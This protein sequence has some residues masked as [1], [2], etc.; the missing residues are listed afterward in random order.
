[1][2][3]RIGLSDAD[4][5]GWPGV[6][7]STLAETCTPIA[8]QIARARV[9]SVGFIPA[10][11]ALAHGEA[12]A[13]LIVAI[14]EALLGFL[15]EEIGIIDSWPT[16]PWG[17]AAVDHRS[18]Y[19]QRWLAPRIVELAPLPCGDPQ[20]A[21]VALQATLAS[22]PERTAVILVNLAGYVEPGVIPSAL[23]FVDGAI[24]VVAS[25]RTLCGG[26]ARM[27]RFVPGRKN[28]GAVLVA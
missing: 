13:P 7:A 26:L 24:L 16:W 2:A 22:R 21:A 14:G 4:R 20:A 23:D 10:A 9:R 6:P 25:R 1:M 11:G 8:R 5:Y 3:P 17:D 18:I 27:A 19:R 12:L 28:L 15:S